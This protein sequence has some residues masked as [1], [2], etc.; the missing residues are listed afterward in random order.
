MAKAIRARHAE[1]DSAVLAWRGAGKAF[2]QANSVLG[3]II[4]LF[5]ELRL[6]PE[7]PT[8]RTPTESPTTR[9]SALQRA[10]EL[11]LFAVRQRPDDMTRD[12]WL[13]ISRDNCGRLRASPL[14]IGFVQ[15]L[16]IKSIRT[17]LETEHDELADS[18]E[19]PEQDEYDYR[20]GC[21]VERGRVESAVRCLL[22][23]G[24]CI[25]ALGGGAYRRVY[26][27]RSGNGQSRKGTSST[28]WRLLFT[29]QA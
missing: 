27:C 29:S 15:L 25:H 6:P 22:E 23:P 28:L 1:G 26:L 17:G 9:L 19:Q 11:L 16:K 4:C 24:L 21:P 12:G 7:P 18:I 8:A 3:E 14:N 10:T 20:G 5:A 2:E 13:G